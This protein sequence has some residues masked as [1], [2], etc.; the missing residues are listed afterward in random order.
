MR[1]WVARRRAPRDVRPE[2]LPSSWMASVV[3]ARAFESAFSV[4]SLLPLLPPPLVEGTSG[5][6]YQRYP[7]MK[8]SDFVSIRYSPTEWRSQP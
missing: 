8:P 3:A 6:T 1:L 4:I 2:H 7:H 5:Q